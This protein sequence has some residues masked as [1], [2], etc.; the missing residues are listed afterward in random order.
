MSGVGPSAAGRDL[1]D[2]CGAARKYAKNVGQVSDPKLRRL[3]GSVAP[4][5]AQH[6]AVLPV[7]QALLAGSAPD[8]IALSPDAAKLPTA[9]GS[10]GFPDAFYPTKDAFPSSEGTVK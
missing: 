8:L 9:G 5:E 7:V 4:V 3:F 2:G 10:V 6:R 1:R